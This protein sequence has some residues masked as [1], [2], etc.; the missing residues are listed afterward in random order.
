MVVIEHYQ[1]VVPGLFIGDIYAASDLELLIKLKISH[2][3]NLSQRKPKFPDQFFYLNID[4]ADSERSNLKR[5][6]NVTN[7][8]IQG[9]INGG[10]NVLVHCAAGISRSATIV[11]AY[12]LFKNKQWTPT[13]AY[14]FLR[15]KR[16]IVRPNEGFQNQL[17]QW[18]LSRQP[19]GN[20]SVQ[21]IRHVSPARRS[22]GRKPIYNRSNQ[23]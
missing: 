17:N 15:S 7:W 13:R 2:I 1:K 8:L 14:E 22:P 6:F 5:Y 11:L 19:S 3:V 4:I 9:A 18:W 21:A 20:A 12:L 10:N 16:P 23:R